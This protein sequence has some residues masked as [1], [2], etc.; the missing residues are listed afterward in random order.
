MEHIFLDTLVAALPLVPVFMGIY[1]VF[2][3][4]ADFDLTIDG[5]FALGGAVVAVALMHGAPVPVAMILA[6]MSAGA[7]GLAT[8]LLHLTLRIPV[9]LAGLVMSLGLFSVNL[10]VL[11]SPTLSLGTGSTLFS[12]AADL[13]FNKASLAISGILAVI[14]L[15][16]L[17]AFALFLKTEIG[18]ALRTTGVNERMARSQGVNDKAL[19]ALSLVIANGLAGLAGCLVVQ[20]QGFVDVNMGTGTFVAGVGAVLLGELLLRPSGS[21]VLRIVLAVVAGTILYELILVVALR[22]GLAASDLS[23]A[24]ALTLII[25]VAAQRYLRPLLSSWTRR[26]REATRDPVS[27]PTDAHQM[28]EM[29]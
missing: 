19:M 28:K 3:I 17:G 29:V 15:V 8:A 4:R 6:V 2:R 1:M 14:L 21:K 25:A 18:L 13:S 20:N 7:T 12:S 5:S 11:G 22:E 27:E 10:H 16:V 9:L 24:T 23:G 26:R